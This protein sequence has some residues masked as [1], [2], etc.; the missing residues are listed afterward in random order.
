MSKKYISTLLSSLLVMFSAN[1]SADI[2]YNYNVAEEVDQLKTEIN[3]LKE[4]ISQELEQQQDVVGK[5]KERLQKP[6]KKMKIESDAINKFV[7]DSEISDKVKSRIVKEIRKV[8]DQAVSKL[9][10]KETNEIEDEE[11]QDKETQAE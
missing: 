11:I 4:T 9:A 8:K 6:L 7:S 3:I 5:K 2:N 10:K 1:A